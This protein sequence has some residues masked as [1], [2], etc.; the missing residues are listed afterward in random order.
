M[1]SDRQIRRKHKQSPSVDHQSEHGQR[2]KWHCRISHAQAIAK[3]FR[4]PIMG[5]A[6]SNKKGQ[7]GQTA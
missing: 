2:P 5:Q 6:V 3:I 1:V 7:R 4:S